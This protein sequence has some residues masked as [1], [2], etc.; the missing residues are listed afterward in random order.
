MPKSTRRG[1][2]HEGDTTDVITNL[3]DAPVERKDAYLKRM[4]KEEKANKDNYKK[5]GSYITLYG[6]KVLIKYKNATGSVYTRY[7]FNAKRYPE[8]LAIIKKNKGFEVDG[9]FLEL[10]TV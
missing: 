4:K 1:S 8:K 2:T 10:K 6:N 5:S 9:A 7:W 3:D